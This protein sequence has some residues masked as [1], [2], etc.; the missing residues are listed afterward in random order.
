MHP[1]SKAPK[2][3]A[4]ESI[5][6]AQPKKR[7]LSNELELY[8]LRIGSQEIL[9]IE[10]LFDAGRWYEQKPLVARAAAQLLKS[11][12]PNYTAD[13]LADF[14]DFYG[15][16]FKISDDFDEVSIRLYCLSKH[17]P[18]LLPV[19]M[20]LFISPIYDEDELQKFTQ[21]HK[22]ALRHQLQ[23]NEVLAYRIF[24]EELFGK[25]HPY[26][27]NSE[28]A[29]YDALK[30]EDLLQHHQ[31]CYLGS[32]CK[33]IVGGKTDDALMDLICQHL[34]Q[35][36]KGNAPI[37]LEIPPL[38]TDVVKKHYPPTKNSTQASIRIGN[39]AMT[40]KHVDYADFSFTNLLLGGY[41][42]ARLMQ[43]LRE[44]KGYTYSIYSS[45][46]NM[47]HGSYFYIYTDVNTEVKDAAL[48]EIYREIER[49]QTEAVSEEELEMVKNYNLGM[50][51]N[52]VDGVFNV[53][54]IWKEIIIEGLP[55]HFFDQLVEA[56]TNISAQQ[57]QEMARLYFNID[58]LTEIVVG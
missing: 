12:T 3:K 33:V 55:T 2:I 4:I 54:A 38:P 42:G 39:R 43:N 51:L 19:V 8:E 10:W 24:T 58:Q 6:L 21:R 11:G 49:L 29:F 50:F 56:T 5:P 1:L 27:Y 31:R 32:S 37:G 45:M 14:F 17:L 35:L 16:R 36:P 47:R 34:E 30:R 52:A 22:Q 57:I 23:K 9:K 41:F 7:V 53:S 13:E 28:P 25:N 46:E 40:R 44:D 18:K 15:A 26:G 20:E 48:T